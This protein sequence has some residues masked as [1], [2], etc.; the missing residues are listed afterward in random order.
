MLLYVR[1]GLSLLCLLPA[2]VH[3]TGDRDS[4]EWV[5][6]SV[7]APRVQQQTFIS[8]AAK[9]R[10]SYHIYTPEAY[11]AGSDRRFPVVYWLHGSG[12]G[13]RGVAPLA[14]HFAAAIRAGKIPPLIVVFPNGLVES[15]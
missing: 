2:Q 4:P 13:L 11:D 14:A 9:T 6:A 3:A 7:I 5:T 1:L 10:V 15:M 12:G 8:A